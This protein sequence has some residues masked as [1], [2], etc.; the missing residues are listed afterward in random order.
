MRYS[1]V[2]SLLL[3]IVGLSWAQNKVSPAGSTT[4]IGPQK[5]LVCYYDSSS[6]VKEGLGKM[7]IDD[8]EP[9]LQFCTYLVYGYAGIE[10]DSYKAVSMNQNLD[11]DLGKG[12]YRSVTRLKR[13]YPHLKVLLSVGG[14]KD[15]ETGEDAKDLPNKYLELLENPTGRMRFINTAYALV[16]T[17]GFDGL[18]VAWQFNKNKPKKVHSGLGSLWKG[19]KKT[20]TGDHIVD[21]NAETHKE[22]YTALM[23]EL[24][25][26]F[27]PENLLLSATVLPNVNS[28]LFYDVPSV[29]NYVDFVNLAAFDFYTPERN[30]E[31]ADLP[32]PL[33]PLPERNP[34]FSVDSQVQ[35]WLRQGCPAS[36]LNVG[37]PTYGR[38]WKMTDDS[39][40]TGVPPVPKVENEAPQGPNTL[41]PGLY[42]WQEVCSLLPNTNNMY[43]KGADAP[44]AKVLDPQKKSGV[45]AYRVADKKGKN[46]I[47]VGY[48]D[49]D[50]GAEKAGY[51]KTLNLGGIA[52]YDLSLD[53]FRGLCTG[54]KYPILRAVKYRLVN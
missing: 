37:V 48:E 32:A 51:V 26:E 50:T 28:S 19:F 5:H 40:L 36:K 52:L 30:P 43:S 45:Y 22:Q 27:R 44:L 53:D 38:P 20:F 35:Y 41:I 47:W 12:L 46:G 25:N 23:R 33:Y 49:P 31:L 1:V 11:L 14:D 17:Y 2:S 18:D 6:F 29:M 34:E 3:L 7:V 4:S 15:I 39:G 42:S 21:E 8:L 54:D 13:K 10:R 24:K 9:A 16:K